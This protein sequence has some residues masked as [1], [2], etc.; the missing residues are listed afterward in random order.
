MTPKG[1][2]AAGGGWETTVLTAAMTMILLSVLA[3]GINLSP[4]Y[5]I[6]SQGRADAGSWPSGSPSTW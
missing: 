2:D 1:S 6:V 4:D 3:I 5:R